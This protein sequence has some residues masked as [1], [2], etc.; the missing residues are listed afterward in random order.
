MVLLTRLGHA[1]TFLLFGI[2]FLTQQAQAESI[3]EAQVK[4]AFL[5]NFAK[6]V[7]WP[8]TTF[9]SATDPFTIC[10]AGRNPLD[11]ALAQTI[12]DKQVDGRPMT[13]RS[14]SNEAEMKG[15]QVL[16]IPGVELPHF[17]RFLSV[18]PPGVLTVSDASEAPDHLRPLT[19]ITF[20]PEATRI[21][22]V[23]STKVAEKCGVEI[24]SK[25][26]S[27]ATSVDR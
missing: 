24:S 11:G 6:F 3:T 22:F 12:R 26:L 10:T 2:A 9:Q 4:S 23:I 7:K 1:L 16:F 19:A 25:L 17:S 13:M 20:V 21:R 27:L 15:C 18:M 14:I 8:S 5:Y